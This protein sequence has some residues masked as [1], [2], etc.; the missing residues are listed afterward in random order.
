MKVRRFEY[1]IK[2]K[3]EGDIRDLT[4]LVEDSVAKSEVR[5]GVVNVF[6]VGS[7][8]AVSTMEYEPGLIEDV[9]AA[10]ERIAPR[11]AEYKH[12]LRWGDDNGR[13]HVRATIIGPSLT[14]PVS[15]G[16]PILGTWQQVVLLEL[17]TRPRERSLVITVMGE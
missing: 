17:D 16:R 6:V 10:L 9:S 4:G 7:T 2:T 5:E 14:V 11:N 12:H 13:S 15:G 1:R 8:A 3:G